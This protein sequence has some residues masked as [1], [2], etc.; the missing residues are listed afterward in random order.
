[1]GKP[2]TEADKALGLL[3]SFNVAYLNG[4][5]EGEHPEIRAKWES[6]RDFLCKLAIS[7][8]KS[9]ASETQASIP[10]YSPGEWAE[11]RK[12][13]GEVAHAMGNPAVHASGDQTIESETLREALRR[14]K[15][16]KEAVQ[17]L[18]DAG[19]NVEAPL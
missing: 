10:P 5:M 3:M 4:V 13:I 9:P 17:R 12:A 16:T 1:M 11:L 19:L 15:L 8:S 7:A 2:L 14:M 6:V 18:R